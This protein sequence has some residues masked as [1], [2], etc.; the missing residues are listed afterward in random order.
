VA[1]DLCVCGHD[2]LHHDVEQGCIEDICRS[3]RRPAT[4]PVSGLTERVAR[5]IDPYPWKREKLRVYHDARQA[6]LKDAR[7]ALAAVADDVDGLA[8][9]LRDHSLM[10]WNHDGVWSCS[11]GPQFEPPTF[12]DREAADRH[13]AEQ[14]AAHI[15][16]GA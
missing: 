10:P 4:G 2:A 12:P 14:L 5:A 3:F 8:G 1:D 6:S 11:C 13:Q 15:R 9:V 7:A 16:D